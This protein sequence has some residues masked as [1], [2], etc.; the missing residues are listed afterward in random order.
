MSKRVVIA[1]AC[2]ISVGAAAYAAWAVGLLDKLTDN[3]HGAIAACED[4]IK[5]SLA[6]PS[7]YRRVRVEYHQQPPLT[8]EEFTAYQR[9][10]YCGLGDLYEPCTDAN[11]ITIA[12]GGQQILA[13]RG[14][15]RP[16]ASQRQQ[17]RAEWISQIFAVLNRRPAAERQTATV[18]VEF[19][20]QNAFG[21]PIRD[22]RSCR[23]GPIHSDGFHKGDIFDPPAGMPA[24]N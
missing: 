2:V 13:Q 23:F 10:T 9:T 1:A 17:A 22:L 4:N 11:A 20:A 12:Y 14:I 6:A 15:R 24:R 19:D 3:S 16:T 5:A 21:A 7:T 18:F 8:L